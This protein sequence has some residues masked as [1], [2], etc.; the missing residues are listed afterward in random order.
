MQCSALHFTIANFCP[1]TNDP[2]I[3]S[4]VCIMCIIYHQRKPRKPTFDLVLS[5][6]T[7]S[8]SWLHHNG[9]L[10]FSFIF[11]YFLSFSSSLFAVFKRTLVRVLY[12]KQIKVLPSFILSWTLSLAVD[13]SACALNTAQTNVSATPIAAL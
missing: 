4:T 2:F 1:M 10:F 5:M 9:T 8:P 13:F 12:A 7:C 11:I 6:Q 3:Y